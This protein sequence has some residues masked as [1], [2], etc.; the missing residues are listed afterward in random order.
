MAVRMG[1]EWYRE[2]TDEGRGA[3]EYVGS[4]SKWGQGQVDARQRG[5]R[6][7]EASKSCIEREITNRR[8]WMMKKGLR[9]GSDGEVD[10]YDAIERRNDGEQS[11]TNRSRPPK[12]Q[13]AK[14]Q[15]NTG[16]AD[17]TNSQHL[18]SSLIFS[19]HINTTQTLSPSFS[20]VIPP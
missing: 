12:Q 5:A 11:D 8:Y 17:V 15:Q 19:T 16:S 4:E 20:N 6:G 2:P 1:G 9:S 18:P 13:K 7:K 14:T 3:A 10:G